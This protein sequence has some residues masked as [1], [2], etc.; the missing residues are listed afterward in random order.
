MENNWSEDHAGDAHDPFPEDEREKSEP[1][2]VLNSASDNFAVEKIFQLVQHDQEDQ[3]RDGQLWGLSKGLPATTKPMTRKTNCLV[4]T[5]AKLPTD[6]NSS[7]IVSTISAL[8]LSKSS[9][10]R[11]NPWALAKSRIEGM[12]VAAIFG[13]AMMACLMNQ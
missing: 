1:D 5:L 13:R 10:G 9:N 3:S 12:A 4:A 11:S 6:L 8:R 7:L 2:R